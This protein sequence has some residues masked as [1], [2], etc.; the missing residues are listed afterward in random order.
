MPRV[1][2]MDRIDQQ[3]EEG[4]HLVPTR[5]QGEG[6]PPFAR[7]RDGT[8]DTA[9]PHPSESQGYAEEAQR[10]FTR[11][12][13]PIIQTFHCRHAPVS[14][15]DARTESR[16]DLTQGSDQLAAGRHSGSS[17]RFKPCVTHLVTGMN[18]NGMIRPFRAQ[19]GYSRH[20][21]LGFN[22]MLN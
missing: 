4:H 8:N 6:R 21:T 18:M 17:G 19:H 22:G 7:M 2:R 14:N 5:V 12:S 3:Q 16:P 13:C 9:V 20:D 11:Q 15:F 1:R 10:G